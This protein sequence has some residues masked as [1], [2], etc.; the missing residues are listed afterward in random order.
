MN[1]QNILITGKIQMDM[2]KIISKKGIEKQFRFLSEQEVTAEDCKWADAYVGFRPSAHFNLSFLKWVHALG[3]GVDSFLFDREWDKDV[4][5]TRTLC[6]FGKRIS[7][8]CLSYILRDVQRHV[9]FESQQTNK[10]WQEW[11]PAMLASQTVVIFGTGVIGQEIARTLSFFGVRTIGVSRTG[12]RKQYF[13]QIIKNSDVKQVLSNVDWVIST[14]PLTKDT[15]E[16]FNDSF[17]SQ[18]RGA[19][20]I[21]VGRGRTVKEA[22]LIEALMEEYIRLAV[23][24]V[25]AQEPLPEESPL[26]T[27]PNVTI[28]PHI[29]ALTSPEEAIDCFLETL[30]RL[31][32]GEPLLNRV[33]IE[34]GY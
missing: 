22:A 5:L 9:Q 7:E 31:E 29:S 13:H 6:S 20:F 27:L 23:L 26:W 4:L 32:N 2:K 19:G 21:N 28:T 17:F 14:L 15:Y 1:I 12:S 8:Y 10:N 34:A 3:A 25:V 33:N 30:D 16:Y 24:D 11:E 18:L